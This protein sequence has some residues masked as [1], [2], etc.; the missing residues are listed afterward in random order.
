MAINPTF[1]AAEKVLKDMHEHLQSVERSWL[2]DWTS[3]EVVVLLK[4]THTYQ[5]I[6]TE[7]AT[8]Q[9]RW[10]IFDSSS[11]VIPLLKSI[12]ANQQIIKEIATNNRD[13]LKFS[14]LHQ[15]SGIDK[16]MRMSKI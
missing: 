11:K 7:L 8:V 4:K 2:D 6:I 15:E 16:N 14:G 13:K 10:K 1:G 12:Q 5:Q 3:S 9:N